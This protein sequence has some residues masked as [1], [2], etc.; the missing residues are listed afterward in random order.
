VHRVKDLLYTTF[1]FNAINTTNR[2]LSARSLTI[3]SRHHGYSN[4]MRSTT[5]R[6]VGCMGTWHS[7]HWVEFCC[8]HFANLHGNQNGLA[9]QCRRC[10][11]IVNHGSIDGTP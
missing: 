8:C 5:F 1:L 7:M 2:E 3:E 9:M 6:N 4:K 10:K 11:N